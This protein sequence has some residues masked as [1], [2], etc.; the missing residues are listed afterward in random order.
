[1]RVDFIGHAAL[2]VR[3]GKLTLLT[4]P[5]WT[6]PA[7]RDQW[8]PYPIPVPERYDLSQVDAV[9]ISHSHEARL[10]APTLRS[11]LAA[12]PNVLALMP[13]RADTAMRDYLRR[14]GFVR[15]RE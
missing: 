1:M 9:Y 8:Y 4:D 11:L 12:A 7:Y 10:H 2:L 3:H 15:I 6:G 13:L 14:I 5:W